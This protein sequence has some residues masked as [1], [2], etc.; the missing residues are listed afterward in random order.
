[1]SMKSAKNFDGCI[2]IHYDAHIVYVRPIL[3]PSNKE[4]VWRVYEERYRE[5]FFM[6]DIVPVMRYV[7][8]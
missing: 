8:R 3:M 5:T 7:D 4:H 6:E 2:L 1:M